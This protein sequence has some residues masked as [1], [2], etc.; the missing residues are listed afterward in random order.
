MILTHNFSNSWKK[1]IVLY[2]DWKWWF[3]NQY[4]IFEHWFKWKDEAYDPKH[5]YY[6]LTFWYTNKELQP[7][8]NIYV[9]YIKSSPFMQILDLVKFRL[10]LKKLIDKIEPDYIYS[11]F[12]YLLSTVPKGDYKIVGF[13]RDITAEMVKAKWGYRKIV[14]NIFYYLDKIAVKKIDILFYNS[15][16][17]ERYFKKLWYKWKVIFSPRKI[18][19]KEYYSN[20]ADDEIVEFKK[21]YDLIGKKIILTIARLVPEKNVEMGIK[22]MK[23]LDNNFRYIIVGEGEQKDYLINLIKELNLEKKVLIYDFVEHKKIWKFYKLADIFWLL[24]KTNFEWIPNVIMEAWYSKVPVIV[25]PLDVFKSLIRKGIDGFILN[26]FNEVELANLTKEVLGNEIL[27]EN[28]I[29]NWY[30]RSLEL[31]SY[32]VWVKEVFK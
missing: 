8:K 3:E 14:G 19:D 9:K 12:I 23:Y 22:A 28:I 4:S 17:L 30:N 10:E 31:E 2:Q 13:L 7:E 18:V 11:P 6:I 1:I 20:V 15:F 26:S 27:L 24:S 29:K 5:K 16:Y 32:H 21:K 25:T